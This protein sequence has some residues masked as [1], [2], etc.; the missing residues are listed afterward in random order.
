MRCRFLGHSTM[1]VSSGTDAVLTDPLLTNRILLKKR[2]LPVGLALGELPPMTAVTVS[3]AHA[4]HLHLPS[5]RL[6]D[7]QATL[8]VP[9]K[10]GRFV[11]KLGFSR[12]I[13]LDAWQSATLGTFTITAVPVNHERGRFFPWQ[14][15]GVNSYVISDGKNALFAAGDMDF[16]PA[17]EMADLRGKFSLTAAALPVGGMREVAWY[18]RR[19]GK[20]GVHID[21]QTAWE[22]FLQTGAQWLIPIHWGAVRVACT[23]VTEPV[24]V[25]METALQAGM[26]E[27]VRVLHP[28]QELNL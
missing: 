4:D 9:P 22:L 8:V 28:G 16:G 20:K 24:D 1:L 19:R 13:E 21:P 18:N 7:R 15:A 26:A 25:L 12:V 3:H 2:C 11:A 5:L 10:A 17:P 14:D 6:L 27:R 23:P